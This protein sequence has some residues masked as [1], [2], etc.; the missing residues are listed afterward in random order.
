MSGSVVAGPVVDPGEAGNAPMAG[1][2][3][4]GAAIRP[5]EKALHVEVLKD[6]ITK[7]NYKK[8]AETGG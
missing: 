5:F 8:Y 2:E 4:R 3:Q 6:S 7:A 1:P